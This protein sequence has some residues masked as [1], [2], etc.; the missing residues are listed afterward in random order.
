MELNLSI[1]DIGYFFK[2]NQKII[3]FFLIFFVIGIICGVIIASSSDSYLSLLTSSDKVF[4]DYV[5]GKANFSKQTMKIILSS[6]FLELI[7]FALSLNFFS[8]LL[9]FV[10]VAYQGS[11]MFLS[12]SAVIAEYGFRGVMMTL[13][14]SL[15]VNLIILASN[16]IFACI[17]FNRSYMAFKLKRFS[18]N[19][20]EGSFWLWVIGIMIF[21]IIF[22]CL[23][24]I[25][26]VIILRS[27]I[28]IIF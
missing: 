11:I 27:R 9:S 8:S 3:F 10:V 5:N 15:P 7:F 12:V 13:L 16:I 28:F 21:N 6:V 20:N 4:F 14:L 24:N 25:L 22:S 23:I 26:F 1:Y 18:Y 2:K 17:C 19:F